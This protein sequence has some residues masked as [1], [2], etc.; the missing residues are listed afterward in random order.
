MALPNHSKR[1]S[2]PP[3]IFGRLYCNFFGKT[4]EKTFTKV[5]NLQYEILDW[6]WPSHLL[7]FSENS[8]ELVAPAFPYGAL[9]TLHRHISK[10][11]PAGIL[12]PTFSSQSLSSWCQ[13]ICTGAVTGRQ[14]YGQRCFSFPGILEKRKTIYRGHVK[15]GLCLVSQT[16]FSS[17]INTGQLCSQEKA[18]LWQC[19]ASDGRF[20]LCGFCDLSFAFAPRALISV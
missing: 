20:C 13:I 7:N 4:S 9:T 18:Q 19:H 16:A 10:S 17:F 6:K 3:L 12:R 15:G 11:K 8:Y 1:P 14:R 2:T 5:Q